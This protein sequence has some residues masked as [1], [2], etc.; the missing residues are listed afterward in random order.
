MWTWDSLT[1]L[2]LCAD[3]FKDITCRSQVCPLVPWAEHV[4]SQEPLY[5]IQHVE[6]TTLYTDTFK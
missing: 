5:V 4:H 3:Q 1:Q 6:F 2:L